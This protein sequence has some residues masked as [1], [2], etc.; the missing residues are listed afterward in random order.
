VLGVITAACLIIA[1]AVLRDVSRDDDAKAPPAAAAA[2]MEPAG[3]PVASRP[4]DDTASPSPASGVTSA[5]PNNDATV[6][7]L[8]VDPQAEGHRVWVD[9]VLLTAEAA[10]VRCG[11][12]QVRVGSTGRAKTVD[13]PCGG[14]ITVF[15]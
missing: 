5:P 11:E 12:H 4:R 7:T 13:V 8:R 15:R 14:E 10:L 2:A 9:G 1:V 3:P 6:G